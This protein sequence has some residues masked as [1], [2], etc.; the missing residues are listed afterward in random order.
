MD[1]ALAF[2][3]GNWGSKPHKDCIFIAKAQLDNLG[4]LQPKLNSLKCAHT[5]I[6]IVAMV[7]YLSFFVRAAPTTMAR[8]DKFLQELSCS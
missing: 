3:A 5:Y 8:I 1:K 4:Y 7:L 2:H 6:H